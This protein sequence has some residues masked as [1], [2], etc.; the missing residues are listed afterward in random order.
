MRVFLIFLLLIFEL[1]NAQTKLPVVIPASPEVSSL[2]N[3]VSFSSSLNTGAAQTSFNLHT[4][5]VGSY[6]MT[7]NVDYTTNGV[8]VDDIP[9]RVGLGWTLNAGGYV[10]RI[11]HDEPDGSAPFLTPPTNLSLKN[12]VLYDFLN[13]ASN[14]GYDTEWDEYSYS[15][16]GYSGKFYVDNN[17]NG[18]SVPLNNLKIKVNGYNQ[19]SKDIEITTPDG[20]KYKFGFTTK[21]NTRQITAQND[22]YTA[23]VTKDNF[24][25]TAWFLDQIVT[26]D[27]EVISLFYTHIICNYTTG[28]FQQMIKPFYN[29]TVCNGVSCPSSVTT[30]TNFTKYDTYYLNKI[31]CS[32]EV[33]DFYYENRPDISGDVRLKTLSIR[34]TQNLISKKLFRFDYYTPSTNN[35]S[36]NKRYFLTGIRQKEIG[37]GSAENIDSGNFLT[38]GYNY[39]DIDNMPDR[40]TYGQDWFGY[41][42]GAT[43]NAYLV[44]FVP[45]IADY[46][47]MGYNGGNRNPSSI[48]DIRKGALK[49]IQL[50]TGGYKEF[51]YEQHTLMT[52][53]STPQYSTASVG[54]GGSG[55]YSPSNFSSNT[56]YI[57]ADQNVQLMS[58][59]KKGPLYTT[60]T[61]G[62]G[63]KIYELKLINTATNQVIVYRKY[64]F[65]QSENINV[66]L[67]GGNTYRLDLTIWGDLNA[68]TANINYNYSSVTSFENRPVPGMRV[69]K[70]MTYDPVSKKRNNVF[71]SYSSYADLSK[72]TAVG[73]TGSANFSMERYGLPCDLGTFQARTE[74]CNSYLVSSNSLFPVNLFSGSPYAYSN[75]IESDDSTFANGF[76]EHMFH[77][78]ITSNVMSTWLGSAS[79]INATNMTTVLN[80]L[81][82]KTRVYKK[83]NS[84]F[85]LLKEVENQ[86]E[87]DNYAAYKDNFYIAKRWDHLGV[88]S[89]IYNDMFNGF[90]LIEYR[91][92]SNWI[93]KKSTTVKDFDENGLNPI[94]KTDT[95][96]YADIS[97][98]QVTKQESTSSS[99]DS[100]TTEFY[101]PIDKGMSAMLS[102]YRIAT[103]VHV[104]HFKSSLLQSETESTYGYFGN[105]LGVSQVEERI[106]GNSGKKV[107][108][109]AY[110]SKGRVTEVKRDNDKL[111]SYIWSSNSD[112]VLAEVQNAS[113]EDIAY[114]SFENDADG[115]WIISSGNRDANTF[116]TGKYG[117]SL[118]NGSIQRNTAY[119]KT[120]TLTYWTQSSSYLYV[121]GT[122]NVKAGPV[123]SNGWRFF[124]HTISGVSNVQLSGWALIDEVSL[125]PSDAQIKTFTHNEL[126]LVSSVL[127]EFGQ[128]TLYTF[129][130]LGRLKQ[131]M[132]ENKNILD[133]YQYVFKEPTM[134]CTSF[135]P[136]WQATGLTRCQKNSSNNNTGYVEQQI[137]DINPCSSSYLQ[138]TWNIM[139]YST[140]SCPVI[141]NCTGNDKR[142]VNGVC[143]T[144]LMVLTGGGYNNGTSYCVYHYEW[145]DGYWSVNYTSYG[146]LCAIE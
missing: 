117:Y 104:K 141:Y 97:H 25:E 109:N 76:T 89:P 30:G 132:D 105:Y 92:V 84:G 52:N 81:E 37:T 131:V 33:V 102:A 146:S 112:R 47:V 83:G 65:Y 63:S 9:S 62:E 39:Y 43:S 85:V 86:F 122:Y 55:E 90:D 110:D 70:V 136:N 10:S 46:V 77:S 88:T 48:E 14:A 99:N 36:N 138:S 120:Y 23:F 34:E 118:S 114:T 57:T 121:P 75:V 115:N 49:N 94:I 64:Y 38:Y 51:D 140:A 32:S 21:E 15:F 12:Q 139:S 144:G 1:G 72:S 3:D 95:Y 137:Q 20:V 7:I 29:S 116:F 56:F 58:E 42:N 87:Y 16:N 60:S 17:G 45:S 128:Y 8:R 108:F 28:N 100:I 91:F 5:K 78:Y 106:L 19:S 135:N 35:S 31:A 18:V 26:I 53:L 27:N 73:P 93:K 126:G 74:V 80:G 134:N 13:S 11:V 103:L 129:D 107:L 145:S 41:N 2:L 59:S 61:T 111:I 44:P 79:S 4:L 127:D 113:K 133:A 67:A 143:E 50:P 24:T 82:Y 98:Q 142:I 69:K 124:E 101:Y 123:H 71:Y 125:Y 54:G 130:G 96:T 22:G 6:Q 68:G 66:F 119:Y 40:L